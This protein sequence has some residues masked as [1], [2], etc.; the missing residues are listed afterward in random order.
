MTRCYVCLEECETTSPC[1]CQMPVHT[2]CLADMHE[3]IPRVDCS[4][5]RSPIQVEY[6]QLKPEPPTVYLNELRNDGSTTSCFIMYVFMIYLIFGWL[7]KL[8]LFACGYQVEPF[9]F[10]TCSHV[11]CFIGMF[12]VVVCVSNSV[13]FCRR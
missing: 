7:G 4:I 3:K 9:P 6:I 5:C 8:F 12:V 10:W 2:E 13:T 11:L 1:E